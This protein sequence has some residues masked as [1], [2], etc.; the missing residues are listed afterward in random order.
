MI[1]ISSILKISTDFILKGESSEEVN[2]SLTEKVAQLSEEH[3]KLVENVVDVYIDDVFSET[4]ENT[5]SFGSTCGI[6]FRGTNTTASTDIGIKDLKI[7]R[8]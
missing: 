5:R 2:N 8:A 4:I 1:K 6:I 7:Y 3:L